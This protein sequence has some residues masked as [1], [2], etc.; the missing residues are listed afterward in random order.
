M[1]S[2]NEEKDTTK[3]IR[4]VLS[5]LFES[6]AEMDEQDEQQRSGTG[7]AR[8]SNKRFDYGFTIG[9]GP[10]SEETG[11]E[12]TESAPI[13][14]TDYA[15]AIHETGEELVAT[16]DLSETNP[17]D[18]S[19]GV[20]ADAGTLLVARDG[21]ILERITLPRG[22]LAVRDASFNNGV[23]DVRLGPTGGDENE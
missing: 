21:E 2:D 9:I 5:A 22:D 13:S 15:T 18:L 23:L 1:T 17:G 7:T 4:T 8:H 12:R 3:T 19:A 10:Q 14:D 6:I 11:H 20:D 16:V